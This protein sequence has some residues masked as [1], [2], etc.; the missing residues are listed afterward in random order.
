M[1]RQILVL[2]VVAAAALTVVGVGLAQSG[3]FND[4][5]VACTDLGTTLQ[6]KGKVSGL[7]GTTFEIVVE[8]DG[9]AV[10]ECTNPGGNV[11]PGQNTALDVSGSSGPLATPRNG[12]FNFTVTT[13]EPTVPNTPTCPNAGW[14]ANVTDVIFSNITITLLEDDVPVDTFP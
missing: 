6:C 7:G 9:L 5:T 10:V 3:H 2:L 1:K 8:A 11:A 13:D 12:N 4:R 14:T